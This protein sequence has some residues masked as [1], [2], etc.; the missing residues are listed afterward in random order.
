MNYRNKKEKR[1]NFNQELENYIQN[2]KKY[3]IGLGAKKT[4]SDAKVIEF[5]AMQNS[6][7]TNNVKMKK[8]PRSKKKFIV[9]L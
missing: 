3:L 9:E 7:Y 8:M 6:M 2:T 5:I 1:M 4:L